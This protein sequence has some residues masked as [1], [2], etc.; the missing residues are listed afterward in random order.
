MIDFL[1][2]LINFFAIYYGSGVMRLCVQLGCFRRRVDLFALKFYLDTVVFHQPF[3]AAENYRD[4]VLPGG[5]DHI[6][7]HFL[8]LT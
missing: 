1:F 8:F 2:A 3:L 7:L 6:H 4:T 5:E